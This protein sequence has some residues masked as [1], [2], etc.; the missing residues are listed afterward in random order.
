[1]ALKT[2]ETVQTRSKGEGPLKRVLILPPR[3]KQDKP[4]GGKQD[5]KSRGRG[6]RGRGRGG[7][8]TRPPKQTDEQREDQAT[9]G[10]GEAAEDDDNRGNR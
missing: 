9:A 8:G 3:S 10:N 7:R 2:D 4:E 1:M 6:G 5:G